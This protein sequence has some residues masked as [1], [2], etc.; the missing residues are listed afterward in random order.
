MAA[1]DESLANFKRGQGFHGRGMG[2]HAH[3]MRIPRLCH[4]RVT[5]LKWTIRRRFID[6]TPVESSKVAYYTP[7]I[8][9]YVVLAAHAFAA[10]VLAAHVL[11]TQARQLVYW[12]RMYW[13]LVYF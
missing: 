6:V 5:P 13:Q 4:G 7:M 12:Q 11:E 9:N 8:F 2:I 1:V 3:S 10:P